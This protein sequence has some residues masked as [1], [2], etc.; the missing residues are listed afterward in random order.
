MIHPETATIVAAKAITVGKP[1][2]KVLRSRKIP[3]RITIGSL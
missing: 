1:D 3:E 2:R